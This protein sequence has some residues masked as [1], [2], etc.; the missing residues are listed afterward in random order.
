MKHF[1]LGFICGLVSGWSLSF[2]KEKDG[3]RIGTNFKEGSIAFKD[4]AVRLG[5]GLKKAYRA[6]K[7]LNQHL[8]AAKQAV[9]DLQN[10]VH[11][12]QQKT[13]SILQTMH[14]DSMKKW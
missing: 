14:S 3:Q 7:T 1:L 12:Y 11:R 8:P 5:H 4:D 13:G 9:S 2:L 10:D 6:N